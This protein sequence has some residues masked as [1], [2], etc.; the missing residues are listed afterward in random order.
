MCGIQQITLANWIEQPQLVY[1]KLEI[2][3]NINTQF[4]KT[5]QESKGEGI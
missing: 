4:P 5:I 3:T 1:A 2:F